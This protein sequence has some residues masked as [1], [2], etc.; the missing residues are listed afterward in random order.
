MPTP[1]SEPQP[2]PQPRALS[3]AFSMPIGIAADAA[4]TGGRALRSRAL[5][6]TA[7]ERTWRERDTHRSLTSAAAS[8]RSGAAQL[9][10]VR[11]QRK[12]QCARCLVHCGQGRMQ[13][14]Q[15]LQEVAW[16][17]LAEAWLSATFSAAM[18]QPRS[19]RLEC[20]QGTLHPRDFAFC[21][22]AS[23]A[24]CVLFQ[25]HFRQRLSVYHL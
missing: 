7:Q 17:S 21:E 12:C 4:P 8:A 2:Q 3:A 15:C 20:C 13:L 19:F 6:A 11:T 5:R 23:T 22:S 9:A 25:T 16:D 18:H 14:A 24:S 10:P 1:Q